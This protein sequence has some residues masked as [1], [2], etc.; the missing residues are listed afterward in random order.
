[1]LEIADW[2][3]WSTDEIS[4]FHRM[5][6]LLACLTGVER[7]TLRDRKQL[8]RI[9]QAKGSRRERD[10]ALLASRHLRFRDAVE[11]LANETPPPALPAT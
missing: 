10:Y 1:V 8:A 9:V 2:K 6:P 4:G 7:W 11:R 3:H 5:A